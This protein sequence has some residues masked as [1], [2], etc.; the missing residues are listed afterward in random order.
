MAVSA[1]VSAWVTTAPLD[2]AQ[3]DER[4]RLAGLISAR[5]GAE[6][7]LQWIRQV[8][9]G[10]CVHATADTVDQVPEGDASWTRSAGIA[11]AVATADCV[12][13]LV[14]HVD[15]LAIGAIHAGWRGLNAQVIPALIRAMD[16][17]VAGLVAWVGPHV[18]ARHYEVGRDVWQHFEGDADSLTPHADP[19]KRYLDLGAVAAAQ[20]RAA[21]VPSV[22]A[23]AWCTYDDRRF[24]S[25]RRAQHAGDGSTGRFASVILLQN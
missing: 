24:Y 3:R 25:Y 7:S 6:V 20:L 4:D 1:R 11:L 18:C 5:S 22:V 15:G 8:H 19:H 21:G 12:P 13:V 10:A 16:V 2:I 14:S 17:P 23:S 9:G